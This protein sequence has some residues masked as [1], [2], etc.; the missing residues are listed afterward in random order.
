MT[1]Q[2][3]HRLVLRTIPADS[4]PTHC[5]NSTCSYHTSPIPSGTYVLGLTTDIITSYENLQ[6]PVCVAQFCLMC[7]ESIFENANIR[8]STLEKSQ[9]I[10]VIDGS[11]DSADIL[12]AANRLMP[13]NARLAKQVPLPQGPF[14]FHYPPNSPEELYCRRLR[15]EEIDEILR[16]VKRYAPA[17]STPTPILAGDG[18]PSLT[19]HRRNDIPPPKE[20]Y[21][22]QGHRRSDR[23][24]QKMADDADRI[25]IRDLSK[26]RK[27]PDEDVGDDLICHCRELEADAEIICCDSEW[28]QIGWFHLSCVKVDKNKRIADPWYCDDCSPHFD[29]SSEHNAVHTDSEDFL[30][31]ET[32]T[33]D[34]A[35]GDSERESSE[36][37]T[38]ADSLSSDDSKSPPTNHFTSINHISNDVLDGTASSA[39][40][41][42]AYSPCMQK[43]SG[44]LDV[45]LDAVSFTDLAPFIHID[46]NRDFSSSPISAP[47]KDSGI[48]LEHV[49]ALEQ[50]KAL[51]PPSR[52]LWLQTESM[53]SCTPLP[54]SS[55]CGLNT[56]ASPRL[57]K[58]AG[59][60]H[61]AVS[62]STP[63]LS[64]LPIIPQKRTSSPFDEYG[65]PMFNQSSIQPS[66]RDTF[67]D[68]NSQDADH[69]DAMNETSIRAHKRSTWPPDTSTTQTN[70]RA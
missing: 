56:G 38:R 36:A 53:P 68:Y 12:Q 61:T 21:R 51:C 33:N 44:T 64:P 3:G 22:K 70:V 7:V 41:H 13:Q 52:L 17:K 23:D 29:T 42:F 32:A 6:V 57:E 50:W 8:D 69:N 10:I 24:L 62:S 66:L 47:A 28:C 18:T 34:S 31:D 60:Q 48:T 58:R 54:L 65:Y 35:D 40:G 5:V 55:T 37:S 30:S 59:P 26:K 11:C 1:F 43:P 25:E 14:P 16:H 46:L 27:R 67:P 45:A 15:E 20:R 63:N 19:I 49:A 2:G 4:S 9:D 39:W